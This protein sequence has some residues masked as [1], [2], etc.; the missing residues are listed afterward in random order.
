MYSYQN[1]DVPR[2]GA[3]PAALPPVRNSTRAAL[4]ISSRPTPPSPTGRQPKKL[5][6]AFSSNNAFS[7]GDPAC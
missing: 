3:R 4:A 7:D 6:Y 1:Q 2:S 5:L